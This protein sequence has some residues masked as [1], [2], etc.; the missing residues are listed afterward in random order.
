MQHGCRAGRAGCGR[1]ACL[2][3]DR[4]DD[5]FA[6]RRGQAGIAGCGR[7]RQ[8]RVAPCRY[9]W[10][11]AGRRRAPRWCADA[12]RARCWRRGGAGHPSRRRARAS[13]RAGE[14]IAD[15]RK[16]AGVGE[17]KGDM[18]VPAVAQI[19]DR[20]GMCRSAGFFGDIRR[21]ARARRRRREGR[22]CRRT[23]GR[24]SVPAH[25]AMAA[26]AR[27]VAASGP[28]SSI[29]AAAAATMRARTFSPCAGSS[30]TVRSSISMQS[31]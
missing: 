5:G 23:G 12:R 28:P 6:R 11:E 26:T 1:L 27:V 22:A 18:H 19:L 9:P 24:W 21:P 3:G 16:E 8:Q 20:I 14:R 2:A 25:A 31:R 29:S 30:S 17:A 10:R 7:L 4:G 15:D 13:L